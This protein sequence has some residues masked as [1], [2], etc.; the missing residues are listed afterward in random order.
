MLTVA[1]PILIVLAIASALLY[2]E[3]RDAARRLRPIPV[4]RRP[5]LRK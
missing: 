1:F 5:R 2:L 4:R 3:R